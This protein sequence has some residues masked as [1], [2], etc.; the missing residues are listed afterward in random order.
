MGEYIISASGAQYGM[1]VN[2]DGTIN[3]KDS[4]SNSLMPTTSYGYV[5]LTWTNGNNT[6]AQFYNTS[7]G[8]LVG[9]IDMTYDTNNNMQTVTKS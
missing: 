7:G 4:I 8:T 6:K 3:V 9:T 5:Y 1:N 2:S